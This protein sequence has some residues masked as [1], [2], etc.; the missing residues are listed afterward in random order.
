MII[1]IIIMF[2]LSLFIAVPVCR[3]LFKNTI[4]T[5]AAYLKRVFVVWVI[6]M[7]I[8]TGIFQSLGIYKPEK[9]KKT[10]A[11]SNYV[12]TEQAPEENE[13]VMQSITEST[14][15]SNSETSAPPSTT[16]QE[17]YV[18][19]NTTENSTL[20]SKVININQWKGYYDDKTGS[21]EIGIF[22]IDNKSFNLCIYGSDGGDIDIRDLACNID[23]TTASYDS[24]SDNY[25][26]DGF[27]LNLVFDPDKKSISIS[28]T[29]KYSNSDGVS[30]NSDFATTYYFTNE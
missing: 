19:E 24:A 3:V 27:K 26:N 14:I 9:T 25:V 29:G 18:A 8:V 28:Q 20:I 2:I 5:T 17:S 15:E 12:S 6:S 16:S 13:A 4:G 11:A 30:Y 10:E 22:P 1:V 21:M 7:M 23:G